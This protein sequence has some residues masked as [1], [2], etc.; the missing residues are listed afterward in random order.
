MKNYL[1][2]TKIKVLIKQIKKYNLTSVFE[3]Y[4]QFNDWISKLNSRQISNINNLDIDPSLIKFPIELL[5]NKSLL[6]CEDYN[7]RIKAMLN[8]NNGDGCWHLFDALCSPNFLKSKN[9][10][11]DMEMISKAK[12]ARYALWVINEDSFIKSKYHKEDLKLIVDATNKDDNS[13]L[14][15]GALAMVAMDEGSIKSPYHQKDMALIA[16]SKKD[17]LQMNHTYPERGLN[18]L[19]VNEVSLKDKYHEENMQILSKDL[20]ASKY[21]LYNIM[22]NPNIIKGENYRIEVKAMVDAKSEVTAIAIYNYIVNPKKGYE[23]SSE[24]YNCGLDLNDINLIGYNERINGNTNPKYLEY[25][26]LLSK[27]DEKYVVFFESIMSNKYFN[28]SPYQ[29]EDLNLL[30]NI[31]DK[32]ILVDLFKFITNSNASISPYHVNDAK[33]ISQTLDSEKRYLLLSKATDEYSINNENHEYDMQY[34][35]KLDLK[36]IDKDLYNKMYYYLFTP[37]G[38]DNKEHI[39]RLEKLYNG[40]DIEEMEQK[41]IIADYLDNLNEEENFKKEPVKIL[42]KIKKVLKK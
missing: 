33:I 36:N 2:E 13:F 34:I 25:L 40:E 15:A 12:T 17:C 42:S 37:N 11:E 38:M 10:Y 7:E 14:T 21:H 18:Y 26:S 5:I 24:L 8:L 1:K 39:I 29:D 6:N 20:I 30:L 27:I 16:T 41:D 22:T 19:A 3:D 28:K 23:V 32:D 35:S 31:V 4:K 9:Y